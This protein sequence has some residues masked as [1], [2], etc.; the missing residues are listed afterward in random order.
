MTEPDQAVIS[1]LSA[2]FATMASYLARASTDLRELQRIVVER[3]P[4]PV[5]EAPEPYYYPQDRKSTR[6]NSSHT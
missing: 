1:R 5:A 3:T 6:L 2:D 4:Q